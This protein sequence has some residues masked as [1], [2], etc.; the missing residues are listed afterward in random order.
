[1]AALRSRRVEIAAFGET[2]RFVSR[3][4]S[5]SDARFRGFERRRR[6]RDARGAVAIFACRLATQTR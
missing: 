1:M 6:E 2:N 5:F 4:F 3:A